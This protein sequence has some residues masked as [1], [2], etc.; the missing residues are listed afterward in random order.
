MHLST[1]YKPKIGREQSFAIGARGLSQALN[2]IPQEGHIQLAFLGACHKD[3]DLHRVMTFQY[4]Y[5]PEFGGRPGWIVWV[6]AVPREFKGRIKTLLIDDALPN[7]ARPWFVARAG[8]LGRI[9]E[10]ALELVFDETQDRVLGV[11]GLTRKRLEPNL[12]PK[13]K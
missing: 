8:L 7:I 12:A 3:S 11:A 2:G 6:S 4:V 5:T 9:G 13:G 1:P 10:E